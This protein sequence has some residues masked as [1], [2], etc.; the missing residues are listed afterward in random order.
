M[1]R[2]NG[3]ILYRAWQIPALR[4]C[5]RG[6]FFRVHLFWLSYSST[7]PVDG[8]YS[9]KP[10]SPGIKAGHGVEHQVIPTARFLGPLSPVIIIHG[11]RC[12]ADQEPSPPPPLL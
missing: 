10:S 4:E 11:L 1:I 12:R 2:S 8:H 7:F 9:P 5:V 6:W 3:T